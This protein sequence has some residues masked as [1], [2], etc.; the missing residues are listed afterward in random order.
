[1]AVELIFEVSGPNKSTPLLNSDP[2]KWSIAQIQALSAHFRA[3]IRRI[4]L[5]TGQGRPPRMTS[6]REPPLQTHP[7]LIAPSSATP[8]PTRRQQ[9][10]VG[11]AL[12]LNNW[13]PGVLQRNA[14]T[15]PML[16]KRTRN[17]RTSTNASAYCSTRPVQ[18][19]TSTKQVL[20]PAS[21]GIRNFW[22]PAEEYRGETHVCA[23]INQTRRRAKLQLL[24]CM[25][26]VSLEFPACSGSP[27][28]AE[29]PD[30]PI[31][32]ECRGR[33]GPGAS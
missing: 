2:E 32:S 16:H 29:F 31:I 27:D 9:P 24:F 6:K 30:H 4:Q 11:Q 28:L 12:C 5:R 14:S 22:A 20:S 33:E 10:S 23:L 7:T 15:E 13:C 26:F 8:P 17:T 19:K 3:D 25:F 21:R 18:S 1:M